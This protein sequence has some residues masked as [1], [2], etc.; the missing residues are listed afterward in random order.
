MVMSWR[1]WRSMTP[2]EALQ[3][4]RGYAAAGRIGY[5]PHA[6]REVFEANAVFA[7]VRVALANAARTTLQPN[8]RWKTVGPD[9]DGDELVVVVIDDGLLVVTVF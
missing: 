3:A 1:G 9:R 7:D 6:R 8:D 4:I 2:T 5:S